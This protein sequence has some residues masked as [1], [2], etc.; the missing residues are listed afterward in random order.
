LQK[1]LSAAGVA[2][3]PALHLATSWPRL[4]RGGLQRLDEWLHGHPGARLVVIDTLARLRDRPGEAVYEEDYRLLAAL[5][6]LGDRYAC[7][8]VVVHHTRKGESGDPLEAVSGTLGLTGAA[9]CVLLLRHHRQSEDGRLFVTG[10]DVDER[11]VP[12]RWDAARCLWSH[13]EDG[14]TSEQRAA[15]EALRRRGGV[16]GPAEVA[17]QLGKS[18]DAVRQLL[19]RMADDHGLIRHG[20]R[21]GTYELPPAADDK[22]T[23]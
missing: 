17:K 8:V 11:E 4:G 1:V 21:K 22:V 7:A 18:P 20:P 9:D 23:R 5:K 16:A 10:R 12:L 14:L 6:D 19:R 2:A 15:L 13:G 3:P